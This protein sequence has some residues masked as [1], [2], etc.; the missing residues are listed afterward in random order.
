M[1]IPVLTQVYDEMRRLA[2]A[3][4]VVGGGDFGLRNLVAPLE[5]AAAKAPG[6]AK[7]ADA[8]KAVVESNEK[9]SADALL[10]L[11]TLVNAILYTQGET[12]LA[13]EFKVI[14]TTPFTHSEVQITARALKPV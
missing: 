10:D 8:V 5:Q 9:T 12:G 2:I 3:G 13:G 11:T 14:E 7:I 4:S 6:F 1:S